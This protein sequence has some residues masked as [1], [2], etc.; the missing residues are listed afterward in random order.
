MKNAVTR[1]PGSPSPRWQMVV[2]MNVSHSTP[3]TRCSTA[4]RVE[5]TPTP[6]VL[7][8]H[9]EIDDVVAVAQSRDFGAALTGAG[10]EV[11][12]EILPDA[13]HDTIYRPEVVADLV[14][15]WLAAL[16]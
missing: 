9:G 14:A 8:A 3:G 13:D 7:L 5:R 1:S 2:P 12:L 15:R 10:H 6:R 4:A 16:G 11:E